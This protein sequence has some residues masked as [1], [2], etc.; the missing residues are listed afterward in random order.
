MA[1]SHPEIDDL[2]QQALAVSDIQSA[3]IFFVAPG[4]TTLELAA[5]AGIA[6]PALEG[7]TAAVRNPEHPVAH[8]LLDDEPTFDVLPMAPGG[9]ML[10]SHLSL[11]APSGQAVG[12]LAVSHDSPLDED[13]RQQ[14]IALAARAATAIIL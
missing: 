5:A 1:V 12:V 11:I 3:A 14:L 6:G 10:R 7:L 13:Q 9:P 8:A 4:S 2:A